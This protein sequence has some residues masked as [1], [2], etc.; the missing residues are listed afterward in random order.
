MGSGKERVENETPKVPGTLGKIGTQIENQS[1]TKP[2]WNAPE[3]PSL[4]NI[5]KYVKKENLIKLQFIPISFDC[6]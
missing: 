1:S 6:F 5:W 4:G 3:S 2:K